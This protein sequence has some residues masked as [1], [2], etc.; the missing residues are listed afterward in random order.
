[1]V[2]LTLFPGASVRAADGAALYQQHCAMC[3]QARGQGVEGIFPPL[4]GSDY[5]V[6]HRESSLRALLEGLSGPIE[7]NGKAYNAAMP[8][9]ALKDEEVSAVMTWVF[10]QWGNTAPAVTLEEVAGVR[11]KTKYPKWEDLNAASACLPPPPSPPGWTL[12]AGPELPI[13]PVRMARHPVTAEILILAASGEIWAWHPEKPALRLFLPPNYV[14]GGAMCLGLCVDRTGRLLISSNQVDNTRSPVESVITI[15]RTPPLTAEAAPAP[16]IWLRLRYPHGIGGFNHGVSA[17]VQGP[18]DFLYMASGSRTDGNEPGTLEDHYQGGEIPLTASVWRINPHSTNPYPVIWCSGL[19][20]PYG[21]AF[22]PSGRLWATDNGP[23][24]DR[25]EELNLL[26]QG[27]HYGFPYQFAAFPASD[28]PY[29]YTPAPPRGLTFALPVMN[30]GP[31]GGGT[32]GKPT[33]TFDPHSCPCGFV[34]M[35]GPACPPADRGSFFVT[36]YG[37]LLAGKD[38]GFDLLRVRPSLLPDGRWEAEVKVLATPLARPIDIIEYSPGRLFIAEFC[39]AVNFQG[40]IGQ[41]GRL[42]EMTAAP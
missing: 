26:T 38:S 16:P 24:A 40:G 20:N 27:A 11:A 41:P 21:L 22:D 7:V 34:W 37:N 36:R 15:W 28:R 3:H 31:D 42:L 23:D 39:R 25:H 19:R 5:I 13:Q 33:G 17:I 4:A 10:S 8:L 1:M 2:L 14:G 9:L 32:A 12:K 35:D 6:K 29:P 30:T 18:D